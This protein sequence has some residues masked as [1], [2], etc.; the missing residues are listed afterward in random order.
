MFDDE[1]EEYLSE[2]KYGFKS[3]ADKKRE[4][5]ARQ[6]REFR[7]RHKTK[8]FNAEF[9]EDECLKELLK[10]LREDGITNKEFIIKSFERYK[11]EGG[12]HD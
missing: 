7:A 8:K 9:K 6:Q 4:R 12:F 2:L 11:K 5:L 10:R 3:K 1:D